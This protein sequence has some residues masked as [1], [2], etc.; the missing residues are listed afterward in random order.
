MTVIKKILK[1]KKESVSDLYRIIGGNRG[2]LFAICAGTARATAPMRER[3]SG[4]LGVSE[5]EL[6]DERGMAKFEQ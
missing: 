1:D 6:F 3:I 5:D 4:A 2:C